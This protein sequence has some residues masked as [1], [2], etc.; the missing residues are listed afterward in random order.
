[1]G[2]RQDFTMY[3]G[4]DKVVTF[5]VLDEGIPF[6]AANVAGAR[7]RLTPEPDADVV[8]LEKWLGAGITVT[9][10]AAS[11]TVRA[12][13]MLPAGTYYHELA[14]KTTAGD[15]YPVSR[16]LLTV[17]PASTLEGEWA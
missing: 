11:V 2:V 1:M 12:T 10:G 13:D 16:G 14:Y 6:I 7:W 15:R 8:L 5:T 17:L 4:Q 3:K 9:D